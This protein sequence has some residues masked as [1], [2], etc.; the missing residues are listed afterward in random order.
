MS[1]E[2]AGFAVEEA[3][4]SSDKHMCKLPTLGQVETQGLK[5]GTVLRC[6]ETI[7][8]TKDGVTKTRECGRKWKLNLPRKLF[9]A[10]R[11]PSE[12]K[13]ATEAKKK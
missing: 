7:T 13:A 4:Q 1:N 6:K 12:K 2:I 5:R 3:A 11:P 10:I 8:E 9:S